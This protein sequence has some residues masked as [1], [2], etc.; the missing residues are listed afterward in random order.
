MD[1]TMD[2]NEATMKINDQHLMKRTRSCHED[3]RRQVRSSR[4]KSA[5]SLDVKMQIE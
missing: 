2:L 4:H 5:R 3:H 1:A